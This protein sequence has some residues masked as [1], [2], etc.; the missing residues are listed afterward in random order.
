ML[1]RGF[2]LSLSLP[3]PRSPFFHAALLHSPLSIHIRFLFSP[4]HA[5][6]LLHSFAS[7][8]SLFSLCS[9]SWSLPPASGL[10]SLR[11]SS[12]PSSDLT[13]F[14]LACPHF[15]CT[16]SHKPSHAILLC[17][18]N[19]SSTS[20]ICSAPLDKHP[21]LSPTPA[22]FT[23]SRIKYQ[24]CLPAWPSTLRIVRY[25]LSLDLLYPTNLRPTLYFPHSPRHFTNISSTYSPCFPFY[26]PDLIS[27]IS[28]AD[29]LHSP[30]IMTF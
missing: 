13:F 12:L 15:E 27:K 28:S 21:L 7:T 9:P 20:T 6:S 14:A 29:C 22:A 19:Y 16:S 4:P 1:A 30:Q 17:F 26:T 3:S 2:S 10:P 8:P 23:L 24:G 5:L 25:H 11:G 18:S